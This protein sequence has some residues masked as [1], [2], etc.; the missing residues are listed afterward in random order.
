MSLQSAFPP[1]QHY[2]DGV[3]NQSAW[4][5]QTYASAALG[6]T[7]SLASS[8]AASA[9]A[10]AALPQALSNNTPSLSG[11]S[12]PSS[13]PPSQNSLYN[14]Y[15]NGA[16]LEQNS[17]LNGA[18]QFAYNMTQ[19]SPNQHSVSPQQTSVWTHHAQNNKMP[20]NLSSWHDNYG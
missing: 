17:V 8:L 16:S 5:Q 20:E 2:G 19:V 11:S 1:Q 12:N 6:S 13:T 18:N 10:S 7:A 3:F 15:N 4:A 9:A 14:A